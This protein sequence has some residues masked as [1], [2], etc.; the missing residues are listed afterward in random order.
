M[1]IEML[2]ICYAGVFA[3]G[4]LL[5]IV[6]TAAAKKLA[7]RL[8]IMDRPKNE[9]HK[10]HKKATPLLGGFAMFM[11][12]SVALAAG[13]CVLCLVPG[14]FEKLPAINFT[15]AACRFT[16]IYTGGMLCVILGL[17]DDIKGMKAHWKFGGQFIIALTAVLLGGV[18]ISAF[19][20]NEIFT[21]CVTVFWFMLL[22]NSINFFDNMDGLAVGTVCIGM[23]IFAV[24][25]A[26]N[27]QFL[28]GGFAFLFTGV[29]MGFWIF[30]HSPA[31]IFMGDSGSHFIGYFAAVVSASVTYFNFEGSLT[32]FPILVP[33]F[34][35]ALPLFDT[36]MV[37]IIRYRLGKPFW[38]GDHNHISH[39]FVR[40]GLN[41]KY[42]VM[43][44][45]ILALLIGLGAFPLMWG[46]F[47]IA[48][49]MVIQILL[50]LLVITI[51]QFK[52]D[53]NNSLTVGGE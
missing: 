40:M 38:I 36:L 48:V 23:G 27:G 43:M 5:T 34:V 17:I 21:V 22:M 13:L 9:M 33:F 53:D 49:I 25:A 12:F 10:G 26:L 31:S 2:D 24:I 44:V 3:A 8:D 30:N 16:W 52:L 4:L 20:P 1:K 7:V 11:G 46:D 42:A 19:I 15:G 28:V 6:F 51:L 45:H 32:K 29:T 14:V 47:K 41:R 50:L 37:C 18:R 39:R 35:L